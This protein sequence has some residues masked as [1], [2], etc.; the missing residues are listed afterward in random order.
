MAEQA[1]EK[2]INTYSKL[3]PDYDG[4]FE[5]LGRFIDACDLLKDSAGTTHVQTAIKLIQTKLGSV[6]RT[7][8]TNED[9]IDKV[10]EKL[11]NSIKPDS[12][13]VINAKLMSIK[14][15]NKTPHDY[16]KDIEEM[17]ESL[18]I[19]YINEGM[20]PALAE[21]QSVDGAVRALI[22]NINNPQVKTVIQSA[23]LKTINDVSTKFL[24]AATEQ[25]NNKAQIFYH[26]KFNRRG[27][28]NQYGRGRNNYGG[29]NSY[30]G[31]YHNGNS[32]RGNRGRG[33]YRGRNNY[34]GNPN[35]NQSVRY[36]ENFQYPQLTLGGESSGSS[37]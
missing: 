16:I 24:S 23:D 30:R 27:N 19:A 33:N 37:A 21:S 6:P 28:R 9:T 5:N 8:I 12:S 1:K 2:F 29:N 11:K 17:T 25:A 4:K 26:K 18:N 13:K 36:A 3:L 34:K 10:V 35:N 22:A 20:P 7:Y 15:G 31:N 14:Q 32:Y